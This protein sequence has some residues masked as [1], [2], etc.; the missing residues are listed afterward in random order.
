MAGTSP[1]TTNI[2]VNDVENAL[3]VSN[4]AMAARTFFDDADDTLYPNLPT[5]IAAPPTSGVR[6][7]A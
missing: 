3:D 7:G 2:C 1:A 4:A 6:H 5:E